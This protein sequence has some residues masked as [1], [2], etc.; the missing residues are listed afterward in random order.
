MKAIVKKKREKGFWIDDVP[1]P[2]I[3]NNEILIKTLKTA[4]CGTDLH[5][6]SWD[7]WA[8]KTLPVPCIVGH[9]CVGIIVDTGCDVH[10]LKKGDR[11]AVEGHTTCGRCSLCLSGKKVLCPNTISFGINRNGCFAEYVAV[12]MDNAFLIP[13][14]ISDELASLFDPLGNAAHTALSFDLVGKNVLIT[15]AGPIGLMAVP[16]AKKAGA[17]N[18]VISDINQYRLSI[19]EK[20]GATKAVNV[21]KDSIEAVMASLNIK[22]GFDVCLEMSGNARAFS[23]LADLSANGA[24]IA[25]LGIIPS[26]AHIDWYKVIFKMLT[27]KG[28]Y[29]REIFRTWFQVL[30]LLESGL[31]VSPI[32]T[33]RLRAEDYQQGI[34][35]MLSGNAGKV[36]LDWSK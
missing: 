22:P 2:K 34:D 13:E 28:I 14:G 24:N 19:A 29:G 20:L 3:K 32:V 12:P 15:G 36:I 10:G 4:I 35:A 31:D 30:A 17:K 25:L 27:I 16:I 1:E 26:D 6:Y 18:V 23:S 5:L 33:H 11:I 7:D 9:E 8:Q 21:S